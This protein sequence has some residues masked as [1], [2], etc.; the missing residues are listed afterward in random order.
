MGLIR[1]L[2]EW[3]SYTVITF[4]VFGEDRVTL[5]GTGLFFIVI[6]SMLSKDFVRLVLI[7]FVIASPISWWAMNKWLQDYQFRITI[8]WW[9]FAAAAGLV[10]L[11]ALV[12]ISFQTL[13]AAMSN[14][15]KSLRA[16]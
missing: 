16:E 12:T 5:A 15:A 13:K 2:E 6:S 1:L 11:I 14:P 4:L 7:S 3:V 9:I 8:G 10:I